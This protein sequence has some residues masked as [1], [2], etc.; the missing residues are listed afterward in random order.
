[1]AIKINNQNAIDNN[2]RGDFV[3]ANIGAYTKTQL[4]DGSIVGTKVGDFVYNTT[5]KKISVWTGSA[6]TGLEDD[7]SITFTSAPAPSLLDGQTFDLRETNNNAI[8]LNEPG[9]FT[10]TFNEPGLSFDFQLVGEG[11][12][13]GQPTR[14]STVLTVSTLTATAGGGAQNSGGTATKTDPGSVP[15][16]FT[17]TNGLTGSNG[18]PGISILEEIQELLDNR[19]LLFTLE[20][21]FPHLKME[22]QRLRLEDNQGVA[23]LGLKVMVVLQD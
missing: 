16:T 6:W 13:G 4:S 7:Y 20:H 8:L 23:R 1:M 12:N 14:P 9:V 3:I 19:L 22:H 11:A 15:G 18:S 17:L 10:F 2:E 5:A 21:Y